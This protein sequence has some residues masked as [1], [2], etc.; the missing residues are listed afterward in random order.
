MSSPPAPSFAVCRL[1]VVPV[2]RF[3]D[4]VSE[5]TTQ[6][7]FGEGV[8]VLEENRGLWRIRI[9]QD[10]YEG[11]VDHRQ[12]T[13]RQQAR[14]PGARVLT[15]ELGGWASHEGERRLLPPGTPLPDWQ[16]GSFRIGGETWQWTG[17][18]HL[19]PERPDWEQLV[20]E[21]AR[22]LHAPYVWGGRT[23]WGIDCSGL[24]QN[25]LAHQGISL[26][27]DCIEQVEQGRSLALLRDAC[28]GDLAFFDGTRDGG[29]HVGLVLAG[30]AILHASGFVR[31]DELTDRGILVHGTGHLSHR[32]TAPRRIAEWSGNGS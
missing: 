27:R 18:V 21:S 20:R 12:F 24:V 30:G 3:A 28:P 9:C 11:W 19:I 7:R 22:Y 29:R 6:V 25:L 31:I 16:D 17:A 1:A 10:G 23:L 13:V 2:R 8:E 5:M 14:P 26:K 15:D 4:M 32:L